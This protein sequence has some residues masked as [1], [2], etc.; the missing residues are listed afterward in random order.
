MKND[1]Y[2]ILNY[3]KVERIKQILG[4]SDEQFKKVLTGEGYLIT[5]KISLGD[6]D[7]WI[8]VGTFIDEADTRAMKKS[9]FRLPLGVGI[10]GI[11]EAL[12]KRRE[13]GLND[14]EMNYFTEKSENELRSFGDDI[15]HKAYLVKNYR[16]YIKS[17]RGANNRIKKCLALNELYINNRVNGRALYKGPDKDTMIA[18][19]MEVAYC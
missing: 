9:A 6:D 11:Y 5:E 8:R 18:A 7:E 19:E 14:N 12:K 4:L 1:T 10:T 2:M 3:D 15:A 17:F 16:E 13:Y